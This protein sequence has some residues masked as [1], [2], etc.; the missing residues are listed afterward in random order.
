MRSFAVRFSIARSHCVVDVGGTPDN[1]LFLPPEA[2][3]RVVLVNT[4]PAIFRQP[5]FEYVLADG[6]RLPFADH[7]FDVAFSNSVIE[8][9]G[10]LQRQRSFAA[11]LSRVS[12]SLFVQTPSRWFLVEPHLI[13][14]GLHF[15]PRSWQLR[16][17][18]WCSLWGWLTRPSSQECLAKLDETRL[19]T[20]TEMQACFPRAKLVR[21]RFFGFT[22]ALIAIK[23]G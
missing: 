2:R 9:V 1:W 10:C 12:A 7:Q 17:I 11:E 21:E 4:D 5:G 20:P 3:P 13:A 22:K 8:H 16:L 14:P 23:T 15:L 6:C 18:P 19:L